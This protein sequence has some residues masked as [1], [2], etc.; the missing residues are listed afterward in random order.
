[1]IP[2][3][4]FQSIHHHIQSLPVALS[5]D[6]K[7]PA[8]ETGRSPKPS[9]EVKNV[10]TIPPFPLT[11]SWRCVQLVTKNFTINQFVLNLANTTVSTAEKDS[12]V[13]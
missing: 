8:R 7:K 3:S 13:A 12:I 10:Q 5:L 11:S 6:L 2:K 9:F 1:L 4:S